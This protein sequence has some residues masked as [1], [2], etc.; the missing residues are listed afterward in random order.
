MNGC[1]SLWVRSA[2][3]ATIL[4]STAS[5][6][7]SAFGAA[8]PEERIFL[9]GRRVDFPQGQGKDEECVRL[10]RFF[11]MRQELSDDFNCGMPRRHGRPH[12]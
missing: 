5:P 11:G 1:H 9:C 4:R 10:T 2:M 3:Q 12:T 6:Q 8:L 7:E